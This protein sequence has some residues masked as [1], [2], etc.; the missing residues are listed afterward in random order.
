MIDAGGPREPFA[1]DLVDKP[2]VEAPLV[3][4]DLVEGP[5]WPLLPPIVMAAVRDEL[6][7]G[8]AADILPRGD[9][10]MLPIFPTD[11]AD[12]EGVAGEACATDPGAGL[13]LALGRGVIGDSGYALARK[14]QFSNG[15]MMRV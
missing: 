5:A 2:L 4:A 12:A 10:R 8:V 15:R 9:V 14:A 13:P 6:L 3:E 11:G 1:G 7:A